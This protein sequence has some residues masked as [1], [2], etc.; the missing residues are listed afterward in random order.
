MERWLQPARVMAFGIATQ[1]THLIPPLCDLIFSLCLCGEKCPNRKHYAIFSRE[2]TAVLEQKMDSHLKPALRSHKAKLLDRMFWNPSIVKAT[3]VR[4]RRAVIN[5]VRSKH[6]SKAIWI[7]IALLL[8]MLAINALNVFNSFVCRDFMSSIEHR[9]MTAFWH[10]AWL[11]LLVFGGSTIA[12]VFFRYAEESL[13]LVWR[14]QLTGRMAHA[15]LDGRAYYKLGTSHALANPDQRITEDVRAFT[16]TTLSFTLLLLNGTITAIS[17]S[18]VLWSISPSLFAFSVGYALL[19]S[20]LTIWLGKPLVRLNFNQFDREADFRSELGHVKKNADLIALSH[21]EGRFRARFDERL[22]HLTSN[23]RKIIKVNRNLS[24][25]TTGYQYLIQIVPALFIAPF[26][27]RGEVEFGVITQSAMAF[28][29]LVGAFSVVVTQF[30]S[31]S[32]YTAIS[33][34]LHE[35]SD[36]LYRAREMK[37]SNVEVV[38]DSH[39]IRFEKL[40]LSMEEGGEPC[41]RD[42]SLTIPLNSRWLVV[43]ER[44]SA[45]VALFRSMASLWIHGQGTIRRPDLED[46]LFLPERPY[47][48][49]GSL[50]ETI[51]RVGLAESTQD[52]AVVGALSSLGLSHLLERCG[53]L[54]KEL[55]WDEVLSISEQHLLSMARILLSRPRLACLDRPGSSI[56][57]ATLTQALNLFSAAGVG[58]VIFGNG[59]ERDL[60]YDGIL[61]IHADGDWSVSGGIDSQNT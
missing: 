53:G 36:A 47:I 22:E 19:G 57:I 26:F 25:F 30:Q 15:Y 7:F 10:N 59:A 50:R 35:L 56:P 46:A 33:G 54:D 45:R 44:D 58:V 42:L 12:A 39:E 17:F 3:H 29:T 41:V 20:L 49:P 4:F 31:L 51:V 38:P 37:E 14:N 13:G 27:I 11:Y 52:S 61:H 43:C 21:R 9:D 28:A 32:S 55:N 6:G 5:L 24:F 2:S 16:Q 48:P 23:A 34:R 1:K 60:C 18:G 8:A 40:S